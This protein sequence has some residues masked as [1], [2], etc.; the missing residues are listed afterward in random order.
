[1]GLLWNVLA[2][3][4]APVRATTWVAEQILAEAERAHYDPS[5]IRRQLEEVDQARQDGRLTEQEAEDLEQEL[6]ARLIESNP[7]RAE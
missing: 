3:P 1:M 5:A 2:L 7:R 4:L 6:V